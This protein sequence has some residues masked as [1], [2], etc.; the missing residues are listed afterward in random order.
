MCLCAVGERVSAGEREG[1][2]LRDGPRSGRARSRPLK[3]WEWGGSQKAARAVGR[4]RNSWSGG[5]V[6]SAYALRCTVAWTVGTLIL[7]NGGGR[8]DRES[9]HL[10]SRGVSEGSR[11]VRW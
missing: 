5:W 1:E 9:I 6:G 8:G 4:W 7:G 10:C 11:D 3:M 2:T